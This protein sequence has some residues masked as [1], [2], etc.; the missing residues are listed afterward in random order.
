MLYGEINSI[1]EKLKSEC[2]VLLNSLAS[3]G[4]PSSALP[5]PGQITGVESAMSLVNLFLFS[6]SPDFD[7]FFFLF[8]G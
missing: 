2:S 7:E 3:L 8:F 1:K 5:A 4:I 6:Y